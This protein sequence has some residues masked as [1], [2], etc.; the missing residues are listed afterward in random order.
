MAITAKYVCDFLSSRIPL[1]PNYAESKTSY[2]S[3]YGVFSKGE[4]RVIIRVA[5]HGTYLFHWV[6]KNEGI[7]LTHSANYAI[8]FKDS[9]KI[10]HNTTIDAEAPPVFIVRQ[11][12]YD[13]SLLDA[14][15]VVIILHSIINLVHSGVYSDPF[16]ET[17]KHAIIWR[18]TTN[19]EP[20]NITSKVAKQTRRRRKF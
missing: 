1:T 3:A 15:D 12:I 19:E 18:E 2:I 9:I 20:K 10:V 16:I 6:G 13:C 17:G 14:E 11:Y 7:D 5:D 4:K 8:T